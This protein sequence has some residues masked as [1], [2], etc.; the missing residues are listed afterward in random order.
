MAYKSWE[1]INEKIQSGK[2]VVVTAEEVI[3]IVRKKV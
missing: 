2:V 3:K 1:E